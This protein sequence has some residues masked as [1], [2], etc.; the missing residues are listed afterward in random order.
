MTSYRTFGAEDSAA[1]PLSNPAS[2]AEAVGAAA[3]VEAATWDSEGGAAPIA[4]EGG[5]DSGTAA[6]ATG[7]AP[8][9]AAAG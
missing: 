2:A 4:M 5:V 7:E 6:A 9:A 8:T 3:V 1:E